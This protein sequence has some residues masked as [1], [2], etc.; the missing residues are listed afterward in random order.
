[1][2]HDHKRDAVGEDHYASIRRSLLSRLVLDGWHASKMRLGNNKILI[3][4]T[5]FFAMPRARR[6]ASFLSLTTPHTIGS[7]LFFLVGFF[8]VK[9]HPSHSHS[10]FLYR[11]LRS[12]HEGTE[13]SG[14]K[15]SG[16]GRVTRT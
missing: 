4:F 3:Q 6:G 16:M 5:C 7:F 8:M 12:R 1:M 2:R 14:R 11:S 13:G 15:E 9:L 10:L